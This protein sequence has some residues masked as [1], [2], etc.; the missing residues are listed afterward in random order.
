[1]RVVPSY[2]AADTVAHD[3]VGKSIALAAVGLSAEADSDLTGW[4]F[5][6]G[7]VQAQAGDE[8]NGLSQRLA[9]SRSK[10]A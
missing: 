4:G 1:M 8:G 6:K 3:T 9:W 5:I 7:G 10:T 2:Q